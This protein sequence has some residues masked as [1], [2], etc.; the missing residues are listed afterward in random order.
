M[1]AVLAVSPLDLL[2]FSKSCFRLLFLLDCCF[3]QMCVCVCYAH[4]FSSRHA[5]K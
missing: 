1:G 4:K 5:A 2:F 3:A